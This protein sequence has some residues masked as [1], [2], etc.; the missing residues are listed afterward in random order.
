M[1]EVLINQIKKALIFAIGL[2]EE[3]NP[4]LKYRPS[5]LLNI[6]DKPIII[7]ILEYLIQRGINSFDLILHHFPEQIEEKLGNGSRWGV[8]FRYHLAKNPEM[9]L[10]TII[11]AVK[12]SEYKNFLLGIGDSLPLLPPL[13][14]EEPLVP[15]FYHNPSKL[16]TG[17]GVLSAEHFKNIPIKTP[18]DSIPAH[19]KN[20]TALEVEPFWSVIGLQELKE[21]NKKFFYTKN[22]LLQLPTGTNKIEPGV[23]MSRFVVLE[24][25][26]KIIPPVLIGENSRIRTGAVIGPDS[27]IENHC[28]IDNHTTISDTLICQNSYVG[29]HLEMI[30]CIVDRNALINLTLSSNLHIEEEFLISTSIPPSIHQILK[31]AAERLLALFLI[32]ILS[33]IYF[34]MRIFYPLK[35]EKKMCLPSTD[36][37]LHWNF[38]DIYSFSGTKWLS[39]LPKL[40]NVIKGELSF[41]GSP[42]RSKEEVEQLPEEWRKLYLTT[43][44]GIINLCEVEHGKA[45]TEDEKYASEVFYAT[46]AGVYFDLKLL[47]R[48]IFK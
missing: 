48:Y 38:F 13:T 42:P 35:K 9:P 10:S 7:H 17:W 20:Y 39:G 43:R 28:I 3:L 37:R 21:T 46:Q 14:S 12:G 4:L 29:E 47:Y 8:N 2:R 1:E 33:P 27:I 25:G 26:V 34:L 18:F 24:P 16:W 32:V 6:A 22:P 19:F 11:P 44:P 40:F 23:W 36:N 30:N 45:A 31:H 41:V 15:I 5:A